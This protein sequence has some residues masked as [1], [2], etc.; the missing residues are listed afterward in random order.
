M[1]PRRL[2]VRAGFRTQLLG[3][4]SRRAHRRQLPRKAEPLRAHILYTHTH[5]IT[6]TGRISSLQ[7]LYDYTQLSGLKFFHFQLTVFTSI[8]VRIH[9]ILV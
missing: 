1:D 3:A 9:R 4:L 8:R 7:M 2:R 5:D 6:D